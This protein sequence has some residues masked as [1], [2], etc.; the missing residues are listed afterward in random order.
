MAG[1]IRTVSEQDEVRPNQDLARI[2]FD[3]LL[4]GLLPVAPRGGVARGFQN[5]RYHCAVIV[6]TNIPPGNTLRHALGD[7]R[8]LP[9]GGFAA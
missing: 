1:R 9:S 7:R 8:H 5:V 2:R 6:T 3:E 4:V